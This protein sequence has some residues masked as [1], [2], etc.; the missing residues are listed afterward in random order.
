M[1]VCDETVNS[2]HLF[3]QNFQ[4]I[5][6]WRTFQSNKFLA[7]RY[8][9]S[10][11]LS[12]VLMTSKKSTGRKLAGIQNNFKSPLLV[13][14]YGQFIFRCS[15]QGDTEATDC[16]FFL[17]YFYC[18]FIRYLKSIFSVSNW[19]T[20]GTTGLDQGKGKEGK[21]RLRSHMSAWQRLASRTQTIVKADSTA[22]GLYTIVLILDYETPMDFS[23]VRKKIKHFILQKV[24]FL[25][26]STRLYFLS[27]K[28]DFCYRVCAY[29]RKDRDR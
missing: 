27:F 15:H 7:R 16:V 20:L 29:P 10:E 13:F 25:D 1:K 5:I 8:E 23:L 22:L 26:L 19:L 18:C 21:E 11:A 3:L 6:F 24:F 17:L 9:I 12:A 28:K 4:G 14:Q 2:L